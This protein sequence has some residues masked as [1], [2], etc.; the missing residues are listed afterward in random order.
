MVIE[1]I[2]VSKEDGDMADI[3]FKVWMHDVSVIQ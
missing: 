1:C 2:P 3:Y